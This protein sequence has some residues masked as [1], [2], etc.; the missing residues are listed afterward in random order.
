MTDQHFT[1]WLTTD[2]GCL[3]QDHCDITVL[4][5]A[6]T[7]YNTAEDGTEL[8]IWSTDIMVN[9]QYYATTRT[10]AADDSHKQ[11]QQQAA[12]L[13]T[14]AGWALAGP[15]AATPTGYIATVTRN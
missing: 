10:P 15:W 4:Q 11:A 2:P 7:G 12:E 6:I 9:P 14:S 8:P 3:D 5:D 1:A 13:L